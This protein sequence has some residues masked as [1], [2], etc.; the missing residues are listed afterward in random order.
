MCLCFQ[1]VAG[2]PMVK[3]VLDR[4]KHS[5]ESMITTLDPGMAPYISKLTF[6]YIS[7]GADSILHSQAQDHVVIILYI[8]ITYGTFSQYKGMMKYNILC[9]KVLHVKSLMGAGQGGQCQALGLIQSC[10]S[11]I[12]KPYLLL[13][14]MTM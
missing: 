14:Y 13:Y 1:G 6:L 4:T 10:W 11:R 5:V 3:Q 12:L 9:C 2:N 8:I 7:V